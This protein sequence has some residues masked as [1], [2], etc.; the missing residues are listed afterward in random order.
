VVY[1]LY[2]EEGATLS[3]AAN[4]LSFF[5]AAEAFLGQCLGGAVQPFGRDF[6]GASARTVAGGDRIQGLAEAAPPPRAPKTAAPVEQGRETRA[7]ID[8]FDD[9]K[10]RDLPIITAPPPRPEPTDP[11]AAPEKQ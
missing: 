2:P 9:F 6:E 10:S 3:R 11:L 7:P 4:R 1:L 5:A 8:L